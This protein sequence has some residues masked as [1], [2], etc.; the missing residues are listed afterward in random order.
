[1]NFIQN[2]TDEPEA[3]MTIYLR[4]GLNLPNAINEY[5]ERFKSES[6][7]KAQIAVEQAEQ[8]AQTQTFEKCID[9]RVTIK[10]LPKSKVSAL[11]AFLNGLGVDFDVEKVEQ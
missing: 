7:I 5:Q 2:N 6:E 10:Q 4:N 11:Q 9:I 3:I 8:V 1:M